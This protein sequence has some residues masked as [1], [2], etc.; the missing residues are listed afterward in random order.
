MVS[1][2]RPLLFSRNQ[3][4]LFVDSQSQR[5]Y[6]S[7]KNKTEAH[8]KLTVFQRNVN[9]TRTSYM[10]GFYCGQNAAVSSAAK[11]NCSS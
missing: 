7:Y 10:G 4:Q 6:R 1:K 5:G 2:Q 11:M 8:L 9:A 3:K